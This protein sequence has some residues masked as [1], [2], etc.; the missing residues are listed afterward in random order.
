MTKKNTF[1]AH[2]QHKQIS[3]K[4]YCVIYSI[5]MQ[6]KKTCG[7]DGIKPDNYQQNGKYIP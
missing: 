5:Y 3:R 7:F 1:L 6:K 4:S 2:T